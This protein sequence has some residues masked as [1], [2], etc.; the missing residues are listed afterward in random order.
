VHWTT[1]RR[2]LATSNDTILRATA[3][4]G[5]WLLLP[6]LV[7]S[8]SFLRS[9]L[10]VFYV[11]V[12]VVVADSFGVDCIYMCRASKTVS[13][14]TGSRSGPPRYRRQLDGDA[15]TVLKMLLSNFVPNTIL[16]TRYYHYQFRLTAAIQ[17]TA[18]S[19]SSRLGSRLEDN[20]GDLA[21]GNF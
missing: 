19:S 7:I 20:F 16:S 12:V 10:F 21:S 2:V 15:C 5:G 13:T 8:A 4:L 18:A 9:V 11:V 17:A 1:E 3:A 14:T 6:P